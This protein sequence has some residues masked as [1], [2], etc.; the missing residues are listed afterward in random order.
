MGDS[1]VKR[2]IDGDYVGRDMFDW[3]Q[4]IAYETLLLDIFP[5]FADSKAGTILAQDVAFSGST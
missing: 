5:R 4:Q 1:R 2:L 3:L